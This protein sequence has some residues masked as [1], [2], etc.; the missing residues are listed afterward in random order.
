M[1]YVERVRSIKLY[2]FRN[3]LNQEI[4]IPDGLTVLMGENMQG[5]TSLLESLFIVST[6]RSFRTRNIG[7][8]VRWG[9]NQ[10]Q[11]ELS[12]DGA[13]VVFSVSLDPKTRSLLLNGERISSFESPLAGKVLY[14]SDEYLDLVSTPSG[15]R[16]LF[17]RLLELSDRENLRLATQYRK[18]VAERNSMLSSGFYNEPLNEVLSD[19]I[20]TISQKWREKRQAFLQLVQASLNLRFPQVF[21]SS[22]TFKFSV[23]TSDIKD[24]SLEMLKKTTL[25]GFQRDKIL[26]NVN[27]REVNTVASRGFLKILLTFVFVR[28]AELI[29]EKQGYVLLLMDDFNA[30]IDEVHWKKVLELLPERHIIAA[31]TKTWEKADFGR[32]YSVLAC[33]QG[34][35]FPI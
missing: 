15:T 13:N 26:L 3:L 17:D 28:T 21:G 19:R 5:K 8:I 10:A 6:G 20:D 12:V 32:P 9:Q 24:L 35:V 23:E 22:Y 7:D 11:I 27:N 2:N 18:L 25:F 30:N 33:E 14:C 34:R 16:R 1:W 31:T 4:E 29:Y